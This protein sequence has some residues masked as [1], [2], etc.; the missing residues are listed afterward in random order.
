MKKIVLLLAVIAIVALA[1]YEVLV[2][3]DNNFMVGRMR[4]TPAVKPYEKP[5]PK[6]DTGLVP[7]GGG[8]LDSAV[9]AAD[10]LQSPLQNHD[11]QTLTRGKKVYF[12]YCVQCHGKNYDGYG[13][14]GQSFT[15]PP[16]NLRSPQ[17]QVKS[18]GALFHE[19][20]YG[21][22]GSRQPALATTIEVTDRWRVVAYVKSLAQQ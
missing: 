1:A 18:E 22:P 20:S 7:F 21:S 8:E 17:V 3:Y 5:L 19:I 14:V 12:T 11:P 6:M 15:P 16:I 9:V 4:Q 10:D 13:T 2:F